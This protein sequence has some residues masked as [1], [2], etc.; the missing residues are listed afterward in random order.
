[1][2]V[3]VLNAGSSSLKAQLLDPE[4]GAL[5]EK[6]V[7]ERVG[8][9]GRTHELA[10]TEVLEHLKGPALRAVGHRVVHGGADFTS[11]VVIDDAVEAAIER[12]IP[13]AP[14]H[15]PA[16]LA[17][18]RAA[19]RALP[20]VPHVAVFDTAFHARMP[21]RA[22][23]YAHRSRGSASERYPP[24]RLPRDL[25]RLRGGSRRS[26]PGATAVRAAG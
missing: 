2:T 8:E 23:T 16:N 4:S 24:L 12:C 18:I 5:V 7:V 25:P 14:L 9:A 13:L 21:R 26:D 22:S 15:N 3:L 11:A 17:G 19:R 20:G 10:V 1:M 6:T